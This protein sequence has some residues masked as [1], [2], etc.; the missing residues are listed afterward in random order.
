MQIDPPAER[1]SVTGAEKKWDK[2][3]AKPGVTDVWEEVLCVILARF[4]SWEF[5]LNK[6]SPTPSGHLLLSK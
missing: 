1:K 3:D 5:H 6:L 2:M 4:L